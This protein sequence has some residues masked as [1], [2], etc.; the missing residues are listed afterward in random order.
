MYTH[1]I[2]YGIVIIYHIVHRSLPPVWEKLWLVWKNASEWHC[3]SLHLFSIVF[4]DSV[5]FDICLWRSW[6]RAFDMATQVAPPPPDVQPRAGP[7]RNV[8]AAPR[9]PPGP[10][11][12][13]PAVDREKV[14]IA[15]SVHWC[16][17]NVGRIGHRGFK[18]R[19]PSLMKKLRVTKKSGCAIFVS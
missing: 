17:Q 18:C 11:R 13:L 4:V 6:S 8:M 2:K 19:C 15:C 10:A 14:R 1:K 7:P 9:G 16:V 12:N 3:S 5:A